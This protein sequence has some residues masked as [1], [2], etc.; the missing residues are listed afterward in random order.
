MSR[1]QPAAFGG[2]D[3]FGPMWADWLR[4][5]WHFMNNRV[6]VD[7]IVRLCPE[8]RRQLYSSTARRAPSRPKNCR[9]VLEGMLQAL[10]T[11][12]PCLAATGSAGHGAQAL[13]LAEWV[14]WE[15]YRRGRAR[16][17]YR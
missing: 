8:T 10:Q 15:V 9:P 1:R 11:P 2:P 17:N 12:L 3:A 6:P 5:A 14:H 16:V 13:S 4:H 7:A